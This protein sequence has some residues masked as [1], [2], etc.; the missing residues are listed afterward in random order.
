MNIKITST[1]SNMVT[2]GKEYKVN[3]TLG[4]LLFVIGDDGS[5]FSFIAND[6]VKFDVI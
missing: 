3:D 6:F 1:E 5:E 4:D 2:V